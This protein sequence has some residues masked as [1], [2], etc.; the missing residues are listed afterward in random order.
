MV[1]HDFVNFPELTNSQLD[2]IGFTSP[3]PQIV[4]DFEA[5]IVKVHDGDT[6]TLR[7]SFR[8]FDFPLRVAGIDAP[9]LNSGGKESG[10]WLRGQVEGDVVEIKIDRD[11][12][13]G[14]YGRLIGG[15]ISRGVDIAN[16][17]LTLGYSVPFG[18]KNEGKIPFLDKVFSLKQWF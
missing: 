11:N 15:I 18:D 2:E 5:T 1:E 3:F 4:E 17:R 10:D 13:V 16:M 9:E 8:G 12:R 14:K 6:V 7:T